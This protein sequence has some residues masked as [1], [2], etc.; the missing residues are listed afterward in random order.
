MF[1]PKKNG[2]LRL[3][4]GYRQ[5]NKIARKNRTPLSLIMEFRDRLQGEQWFTALYLKG[6]YNLIWIKEGD[7]W[8][9]ALITKSGYYEYLAM[10]FGLTNAPVTFQR[11]INQV[12]WEYLDIFLIVYLDDILIFS[13]DL[14]W[15]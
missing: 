10:P 6:A 12:L 11:M 5:L 15:G 8:K 4:V 9:T 13:D 1:V 14:E 7:E 3:V 2:K